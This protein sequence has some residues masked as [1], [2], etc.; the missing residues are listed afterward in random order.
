VDSATTF[1]DYATTFKGSQ[2]VRIRNEL[3][4]IL[5]YFGKEVRIA[6]FAVRHGLVEGFWLR[7]FHN[8]IATVFNKAT[9]DDDDFVMIDLSGDRAT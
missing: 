9:G 5:D 4:K 6:T 7:P 2:A 1:H 8:Y 3:Q